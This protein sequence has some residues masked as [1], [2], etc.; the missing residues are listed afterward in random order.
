MSTDDAADGLAAIE[1]GA[2]DPT[3]DLATVL[4][5]CL[6]LGKATGSEKLR[7]WASRELMGYESDDDL[8]A[9]RVT[10]AMLY[11]DGFNVVGRISHQHVPATLLPDVARDLPNR[12]I[13]LRE[14]LATLLHHLGNAQQ[15]G[16]K[17]VLIAPP[18]VEA[19][20]P[21]MNHQLATAASS[22]AAPRQKVESV[23][24]AV[25]FAIFTGVADNVRTILVQLAAEIRA[26]LPVGATL[27]SRELADQSLNVAVHGD[28]NQVVVGQAT[29]GGTAVAGGNAASVGASESRAKTIAWWVFGIIGSAGALAAIIAL[30]HH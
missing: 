2:L 4:R 27:P 30:V 23:Y 20:V 24:W 12:D 8:P 16:D 9:Y 7:A 28:N 11:M 5:Q 17:A 21:L 25:P 18:G 3:S 14:P 6:A 15:S 29:L 13:E 19:L 26:G 1:A 22:G 10:H